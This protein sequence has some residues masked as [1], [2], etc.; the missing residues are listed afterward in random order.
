M[1]ILLVSSELRPVACVD[2]GPDHSGAALE[3]GSSIRRCPQSVLVVTRRNPL[4]RRA[5]ITTIRDNL[6]L[7]DSAANCRPF[8]LA[9]ALLPLRR[10]Y[11][12]RNRPRS[13]SVPEA[14]AGSFAPESPPCYTN[15]APGRVP[16]VVRQ[17]T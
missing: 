3:T 9:Q 11:R 10:T 15:P 14:T 12:S 4:T 8:A 2:N 7:L 16:S 5:V 6:M 17:N 13:T 1:S